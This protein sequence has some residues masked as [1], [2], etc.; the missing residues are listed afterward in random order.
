MSV[1]D[2]VEALIT[3]DIINVDGMSVLDLVEALITSDVVHASNF[4]EERST[5]SYLYVFHCTN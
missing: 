5:R 3:S 1:R 4:E 2:L